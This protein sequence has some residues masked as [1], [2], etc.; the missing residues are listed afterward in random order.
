MRRMLLRAASC[1]FVECEVVIVV[2]V[3]VLLVV[4]LVSLSVCVRKGS[5]GISTTSVA[6]SSRQSS[7]LGPFVFFFFLVVVSAAILAA[8]IVLVLL[9]TLSSEHQG[10]GCR[11]EFTPPLV[12]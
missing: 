9:K 6:G 10:V 5:I 3:V 12:F 11:C 4:V 1:L 8:A 7:A 2:R